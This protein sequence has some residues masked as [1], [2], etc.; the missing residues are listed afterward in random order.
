MEPYVPAI[1]W[2]TLYELV[3]Y[4]GEGFFAVIFVWPTPGMGAYLIGPY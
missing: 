3:G 4:C 2:Y 1:V